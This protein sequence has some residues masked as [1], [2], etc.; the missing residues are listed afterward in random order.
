[1]NTAHSVGEYISGAPA[2]I[3][4]ALRDLRRV[5]RKT[6]PDSE[7]KISYGMPYYGYKGRLVY[8]AYAKDHIGIYIPPPIISD[9]A[10][11]LKKYSTAKSTVRFPIGKKLP[12][13]LIAR[14]VKARVKFNTDTA[15]KI[16]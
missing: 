9:F 4:S 7:E 1:M 3:Q 6:A 12:L 10:D 8:F 16:R 11:E 15:K 13:S 5:I 14:L 2:E